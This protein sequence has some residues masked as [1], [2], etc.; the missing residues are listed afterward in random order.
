MTTS[1]SLNGLPLLATTTVLYGLLS[2]FVA[3][4]VGEWVAMLACLYGTF[5]MLYAALWLMASADR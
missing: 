4:S 1:K 2:A 3:D 5:I